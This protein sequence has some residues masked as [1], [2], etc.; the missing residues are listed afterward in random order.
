MT[1]KQK[2]TPSKLCLHCKTVKPLIEFYKNDGWTEQNQHDVYCKDCARE[3]CID[4][5][6]LRKY[7]WNNNRLWREEIWTAGKEKAEKALTVDA[8]YIS[9]S[10]KQS[11]KNK[12]LDEET[13]HRCLTMM[14]YPLYYVYAENS[15]DDAPL[16]EFDA[17]T[18]M[19]AELTDVDGNSVVEDTVKVYSPDW[20]GMYTKSEIEWLDNYY[21]GLDEAYVLD[22]INIKDY[23]RKVARASLEVDKRYNRLLAGTGSSKEYEAAMD[24]FDKIS[25]SANFA[26]CQRKE[27]T[28]NGM[29]SLSEIIYQIEFEHREQYE[30]VTFPPDDIDRILADFA[31][32]DIAIQ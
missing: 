12:M 28:N 16:M 17:K 14:N 8:D 1:N 30:P 7:F 6:T 22:N 32:T 27:P 9:P 3:L 23:A 11:V 5:D 29:G 18:N 13:A 24:I 4:K 31:H 2:K 15:Q 19:G 25:K 26:A 20:G 21:E 10:T